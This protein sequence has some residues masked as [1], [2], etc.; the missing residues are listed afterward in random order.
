MSGYNEQRGDGWK[1]EADASMQQ[2]DAFAVALGQFRESMHESAKRPD[3]FWARQR[4]AIREHLRTP[5]MAHPI[6]AAHR[7]NAAHQRPPAL[8][9][10][11]S[12]LMLLLCVLLFSEKNPIPAVSFAA[13]ADHDLLI[14]VERALR[15]QCPDALAPAGML[16]QE[17][18][19]DVM[20]TEK[21]PPRK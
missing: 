4:V 15:R 8:I 20:Q 6:N 12:G 7:A 17:L 21:I 18:A 13:G 3:A 2:Q 16:S 9:W 10:A 14:E 11:A 1:P 19:A 5:D